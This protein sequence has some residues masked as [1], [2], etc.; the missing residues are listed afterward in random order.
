MTT[1]IS[2]QRHVDT[3]GRTALF[4]ILCLC[5]LTSRAS[6]SQRGAVESAVGA[7]AAVRSVHYRLASTAPLSIR[8]RT[9]PTC[10]LSLFA[11]ILW[12]LSLRVR[13]PHQT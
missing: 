12:S 7:F 1:T 9:T 5:L 4:P 11:H 2:G 10:E 3:Y 6:L 8:P 13:Q